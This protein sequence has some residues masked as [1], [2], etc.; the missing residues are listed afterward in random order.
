MEVALSINVGAALVDVSPLS[1]IGTSSP[2]P[3]PIFS[4]LPM[5]SKLMRSPSFCLSRSRKRPAAWLWTEAGS[6]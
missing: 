4:T 6:W 3:R 1:T 5:S 2:E